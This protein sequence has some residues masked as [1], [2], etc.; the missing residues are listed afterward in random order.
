MSERVAAEE[1]ADIKLQLRSKHHSV[2]PELFNAQRQ[3]LF[4]ASYLLAV[5]LSTSTISLVK[6]HLN[7]IMVLEGVSLEE[8]RAQIDVQ[9]AVLEAQL[10]EL[11][12][13]RNRFSPTAK[14]PTELLRLIFV[15]YRR[16][17][18]SRSGFDYMKRQPKLKWMRVAFV[19]QRWRDTA[20]STSSLWEV[21]SINWM[22]DI[23]KAMLK[24][25]GS[26]LLSVTGKIRAA[27]LLRLSTVLQ[28]IHRIRAI[29][30]E[31]SEDA[32]PTFFRA[33]IGAAPNLERLTLVNSE[34]ASTREL[35]GHLFDGQTPSLREVTINGLAI[36]LHSSL[37]TNLT[38]LNLAQEGD[39]TI[40]PLC[41]DFMDALTSCPSLVKLNVEHACC[42]ITHPEAALWL[43][44]T[45]RLSYL[46]R[47]DISDDLPSS[48]HLL[49]HL[50]FPSTAIKN[51]VA[52]VFPDTVA[53]IDQ[54]PRLFS[55]IM[56]CFQAEPEDARLG[57]LNISTAPS[58]LSSSIY[59]QPPAFPKHSTLLVLVKAH[60]D[61]D[62]FR[63]WVTST[64][65]NVCSALRLQRITKLIVS[66]DGLGS[67][68]WQAAFGHARSLENVTV[69][70]AA[71]RTMVGWTR[72]QTWCQ[73]HADGPENSLNKGW[74]GAPP[75][76]QP[77]LEATKVVSLSG[78][79]MADLA[80]Q[81]HTSGMDMI[82]SWYQLMRKRPVPLEKL[83]VRAI[84]GTADNL[85]VL[86][87]DGIN[88]LSLW[89]DSEDEE[90]SS[91]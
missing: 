25:S 80:V 36:N 59:L 8:K 41:A 39:G 35:Q 45:C 28:H 14:L 38:T 15:H 70:G 74:E 89:V 55:P 11:K 5:T 19:C 43:T 44:R 27:N 65:V 40:R 4:I 16:R 47:L 31:L 77:V 71:V 24:R 51:I 88:V 91:E 37:F 50:E 21:V 6:A 7:D 84:P 67:G 81:P 3:L 60:H 20:M 83:I 73:V 56:S 75:K 18:A 23:I 76:D 86:R 13:Q 58:S 85:E 49:K 9:I 34:L 64:V 61:S 53:A 78:F 57:T 54:Y 66:H 10:R 87:Q 79:D 12:M 17:F 72:G 52:R 29:D 82:R 69:Y 90:A 33:A 68:H 22:T 2:R 46:E 63:E 48:S 1:K 62:H 32:A 42:A 26:T 30:F